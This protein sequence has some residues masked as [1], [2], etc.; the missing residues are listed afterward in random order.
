MT[1]GRE[2]KRQ[3]NRQARIAGYDR[4]GSTSVEFAGPRRRE[5]LAARGHAFMT[6]I[7]YRET[8]RPRRRMDRERWTTERIG[9]RRTSRR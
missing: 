3:I 8:R 2:V 9:R 6:W 5:A 4:T 1:M 7:E